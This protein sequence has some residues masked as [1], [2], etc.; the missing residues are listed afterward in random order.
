MSGSYVSTMLFKSI[1]PAAAVFARQAAAQAAGTSNTATG[2]P[3]V[4]PNATAT[5]FAPGVP[6]DAPVPGNYTSY[7]RPRVHFTPPRYFMN[8]PNGMHRSPDGTW[9]L[10]YQYNPITPVAGN[11]HWGHAT[12][13]DLYTWTNQ[14]IPFFPPNDY[15]Y[16]FS[17]SAVVDTNNTSGFFPDQDNGVV[18]IYTAA[19][20][21]NGQQGVQYQAIAYSR[22]GGY[23]F[24]AYEGNPVLNLNLT[25]FRDPHVIWHAATS[26]WVMTVA[27]ATEFVIGIYTSSDLKEWEF[28]SNFTSHGYLG[29]QYECPNLVQ[30]PMRGQDEPVWFLLISIN[31]GGPRGGSVSQYFPGEFNGTHFVPFDGA[32][33][34]TDFGKDNYAAQFFYGTEAGQA[35]IALGWAS[36]WQY[37]SLVPTGLI[38]NGQFRSAMTVPRTFELA[39]I[40]MRGYDLVSAPY[41][42]EAVLDNE[43]AYNSSLGNG[44]VISYFADKVESG[45]IYLEANITGLTSTT[46][47]GTA[48]FTISSSVTGEYIRG[49]IK[50]AGEPGIWIDRGNLLGFSENPYF[51]DKFSEEGTFVA[52]DG[53]W[54]LKVVY[55]NS[56]I[57][58]FLNG[59]Q[60]VGTL[61]VFPSRQLDT[62]AVFVGGIP[63][64]ASSSVGI[65][66][67]K[68]TW[69]PQADGNGTVQGNVTQSSG[70]V[71]QR[72]LFGEQ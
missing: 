63:A 30:V 47:R 48:N 43:L 11:Q 55:D 33:R 62:V 69:A 14:K 6:T 7:L 22:D 70:Y 66:G 25:Q 24:E 39:N 20:Y 1:I 71:S 19:E 28:A 29:V 18:A 58:V 35:P 23:S 61:S 16:L 9:H 50:V 65:W 32:T 13:Q 72:S 36:N 64:N 38:E 45:A 68:D 26:R 44:S 53:S 10:Y 21:P 4:F 40:S 37:T 3:D 17:G 59:A 56:I 2:L 41:N 31:P 27:F 8:D 15:T 34:L 12:S 54:D 5:Y 60:A 51:S 46:R 52:D 42:I 67:L 57:E 49:G